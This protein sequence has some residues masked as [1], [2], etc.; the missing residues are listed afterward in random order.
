MANQADFIRELADAMLAS[1]VYETELGVTLNRVVSGL[2]QRV[3]YPK[4]GEGA[5]LSKGQKD[6]VRKIL[7]NGYK[8]KIIDGEK[9]YY[10]GAYLTYI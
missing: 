2:E 8:S 10:R 7:D 6:Y 1:A 4:A 3:D 9:H 5:R